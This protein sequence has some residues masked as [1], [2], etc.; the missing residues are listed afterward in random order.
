M[1]NTRTKLIAL[2]VAASLAAGLCGCTEHSGNGGK[3]EGTIS[4]G[5][6]ER[7]VGLD[8][9]FLEEGEPDTETEVH[10]FE[11][12]IFQNVLTKL[13]GT[14]L[15]GDAY[16]YRDLLPEEYKK[17]YDMLRAG[18]AEGKTEI[19]VEAVVPKEAFRDLYRAVFYD[20]PDFFWW[21]GGVRYSYNQY[22]CITKIKPDYNDLAADI[23]ANKAAFDA[24]LVKAL[25]DM[26]SLPDD[27][28][29]AKYAH[30]FLVD[31]VDYTY[32][33]P[34]GQTAYGAVVDRKCVCA[35]YSRAFQYMM[36]KMGIRCAYI[37]GIS[38]S[39]AGSGSHAWNIV[40]LD[41]EFYA[42]DVTWDDP[43]GAQPGSFCYDYF[44][45]TDEA[46]AAS[47]ARTA[48]SDGL[49]AAT[50][51]ADNFANAFGGSLFGTDF[52]AYS[53]ILPEG[54]AG[55]DTVFLE[56][57]PEVPAETEIADNPF[58]G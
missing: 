1:K 18:I 29:R 22:G 31:T 51:T 24:A 54:S 28:S 38:S 14:A 2:L 7:G 40:E 52:A 57:V 50:G 58:L 42:M 4:V 45:T 10:R 13:D 17:V 5:G 44:N 33:M 41:G 27:V 12:P 23:P 55:T 43:L 9:E 26:W 34:H 32:D 21:N 37:L 53:G 49:P 36:Q 20:S 11:G 47:H 19:P 35:G 8:T 46:I 48:P 15:R 3:T 16:F 25:A 56:P 30:D 6:F 39:E